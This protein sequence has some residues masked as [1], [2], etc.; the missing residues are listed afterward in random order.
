MVYVRM[1]VYMCSQHWKDQRSQ[2]ANIM[3][4]VSGSRGGGGVGEGLRFIRSR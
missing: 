4:W 1:Y 2:V 3:G